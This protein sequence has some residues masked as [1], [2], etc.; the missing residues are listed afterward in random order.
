MVTSKLKIGVLG[1]IALGVFAV[2]GGAFV[3]DEPAATRAERVQ[4]PPAPKA[5][6]PSGRDQAGAEADLDRKILRRIV[7]AAKQKQEANRAYYEEGRITI[8]RYIAATR[9]LRDAEAEAATTQQERAD[10]ARAHRDRVGEILKRE[11]DDWKRGRRTRADLAEA[12][13]AMDHAEYDCLRAR[14]GTPPADVAALERRVR[15]LEQKLDR[16]LKVLG[17]AGLD[18]AAKPVEGE[19]PRRKDSFTVPRR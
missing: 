6:D 16:V 17:T 12:Q 7:A 4:A 5:S 10:A 18:P 8:D 13:L 19:S 1:L 2:A 3:G 11:Q 14:A 9:E 15:E